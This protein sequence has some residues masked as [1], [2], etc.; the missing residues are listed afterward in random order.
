MKKSLG[1]LARRK[2]A[3]LAD[4]VRKALAAVGIEPE[5]VEVDDS[6]PIVPLGCDPGYPVAPAFNA[7]TATPAAR[8]YDRGIRGA[9][10]VRHG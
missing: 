3:G 4:Q 7:R 2:A 5:S 10:G 1:E 9:A 8:A 6:I